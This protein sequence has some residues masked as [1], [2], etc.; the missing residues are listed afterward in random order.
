[1]FLF[2]FYAANGFLISL[3]PIVFAR[4]EPLTDWIR[5]FSSLG[6][7]LVFRLYPRSDLRNFYR[8]AFPFIAAALFF[9]TFS[10]YR[11]P[12][13]VFLE[14][15]LSFLDLYAWLLLI[16][17]ASR[18]GL[19]RGAVINLGISIIV[20]AGTVSHFSILFRT[21]ASLFPGQS[22]QVSFALLGIFLLLLLLSLWDGREVSL[23]TG[24][25]GA[26]GK[27]RDEEEFAGGDDGGDM[28]EADPEVKEKEEEMGR[29]MK[30]MEFNLTRQETEIALLLLKGAKDLNICSLLYIS[31]NTLKYHL[32]NIYRKT[33]S[34]NRR[35]LKNILD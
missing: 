12:A 13:R 5:V 35:E 17:F 28:G 26:P 15:G 11:T 16:Y 23:T 30:L 14:G 3:V 6:A 4:T 34:S 18:T 22:N 20:L 10:P 33:G 32:R 8:G 7:A 9:L 21:G 24:G 25:G 2:C 1:M 19:R 29:R 27:K 31:Q